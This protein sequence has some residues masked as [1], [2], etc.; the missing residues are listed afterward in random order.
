M[1]GARPAAK[2]VNSS[3]HFPGA[4]GDDDPLNLPPMAEMKDI[5][6]VPAPLRTN[7]RFEPGIVAEALDQFG[8]VG[9]GRPSRDERGA[10]RIVLTA[11]PLPDWRQMSS[12]PC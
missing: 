3:A 12:T 11:Q 6:Q 8:C 2:L 10:H 5:A 7:G 4:E 9:K 1:N